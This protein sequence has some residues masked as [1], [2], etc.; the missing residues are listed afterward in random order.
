MKLALAFVLLVGCGGDHPPP[1]APVE[2]KQAPEPQPDPAL[3]EANL[4]AE[5]A[6]REAQDAIKAAHE[7]EERLDQISRDL[8]ALDQRVSAAVDQVVAAQNN[9]E[10]AT[11]SER[12]KELQRQKAEMEQRIGEAKAAAEKAQ[13]KKGVKISQDCMDNPLAKGCS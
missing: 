7:V 8:A 2:N 11:A 12:L 1:Q 3:R 6:E 9:A 4:R 13:R 5:R 10:R